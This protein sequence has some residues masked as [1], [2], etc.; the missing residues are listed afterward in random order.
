MVICKLT[1]LVLTI[2]LAN[3]SS[4]RIRTLAT[5]SEI[6]FTLDD[7]IWRE[8]K[9]TNLQSIWLTFH[10]VLK[11]KEKRQ[12]ATEISKIPKSENTPVKTEDEDG[13]PIEWVKM[14][15]EA[16][17]QWKQDID[18]KKGLEE[19]KKFLIDLF[20]IADNAT[21]ERLIARTEAFVPDQ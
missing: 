8:L 17:I 3:V 1:F 19:K 18:N 6:T 15:D 5:P 12:I 4:H 7:P 20:K 2:V 10:S 14:R 16:V 11:I 13:S 9:D 21:Q